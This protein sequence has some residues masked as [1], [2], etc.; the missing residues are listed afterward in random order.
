MNAAPVV[1]YARDRGYPT[2]A[3]LAVGTTTDG[4]PWVVYEYLEGSPPARLGMAEAEFLIGLVTQAVGMEPPTE[5]DWS[6]YIVPYIFEDLRGHQF[7][8]RSLGGAVAQAVDAVV[9]VARAFQ[10]TSLPHGDLVHGDLSLGNLICREGKPLG[11]VDIEAVGRGTAMYDL[12]CV[13]R[14]A[15]LDGAGEGV[16]P[17]LES[18]AT[19]L[20]EPEVIALCLATQVIEIL[21]F[22]TT[23]FPESLQACA[24][25]MLN[26]VENCRRLIGLAG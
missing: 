21:Q 11:V 16:V 3:W 18:A 8:L 23:H 15:Y 26:W 2:P 25:R 13:L 20:G 9:E 24:S 14:T 12:M 19:D 1:R 22:G 4:Y 10:D 7:Q 17:L 5:M 6:S